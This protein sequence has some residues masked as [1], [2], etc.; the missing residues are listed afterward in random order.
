VS[1]SFVQTCSTNWSAP[2]CTTVPVVSLQFSHSVVSIDRHCSTVFSFQTHLYVLY[3][4]LHF[5]YIKLL[6]AKEGE[7]LNNLGQGERLCCRS[8]AI[9]NLIC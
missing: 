2:S 5:I 9:V 3:V 4:F 1:F 6:I 7:R 8:G